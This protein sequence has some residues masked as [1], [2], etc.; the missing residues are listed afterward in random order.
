MR[1]RRN[2]WVWEEKFNN[3]LSASVMIGTGLVWLDYYWMAAGNWEIGFGSNTFH[4]TFKSES[5]HRC[6]L[7]LERHA[8][9]T[10]HH[11]QRFS[12]R[13]GGSVFRIADH[14]PLATDHVGP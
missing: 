5:N 8:K 12:P 10:Q 4:L 9:R 7:Q 6:M 11:Q 3:S 1:R 13:A 14:V 2:L